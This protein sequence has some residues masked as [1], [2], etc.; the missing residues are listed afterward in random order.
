MRDERRYVCMEVDVFAKRKHIVGKY[1]Q[2]C[3]LV[4]GIMRLDDKLSPQKILKT[5]LC[6][7]L[8]VRN[9]QQ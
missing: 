7:L 4:N 8:P 9:H 6:L 2:Q 3:A 5:L 1:H